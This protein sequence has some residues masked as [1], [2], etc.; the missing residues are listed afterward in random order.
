MVRNATTDSDRMKIVKSYNE[1]KDARTIAEVLGLKIGAV[2]AAIAIYKKENRDTKKRRGRPRQAALNDANKL[3]I[4]EWVD[5]DCSITL[6]RL[7]QKC[8]SELNVNASEKT[9]G[10]CLDGF[11]YTVKRV[12]I[13]PERRNTEEVRVSRAEYARRFMDVLTQTDHNLIFYLD[14]AGFS[15]SMRARRGRSAR[16]TRA[17]QV[18]AAIRTRNI[19]LMCAMSK[20]G[21]FHYSHQPRA[22]NTETFKASIDTLIINL[23]E[24]GIQNAVL[25]LDNVAFHKAQI[26]REVVER[27]GHTLMFLPPYSPFLNPIENMFSK[28]KEAVRRSRPTDEHDLIQ[29]VEAGSTLVTAEDCDGYFRHMIGFLTRCINREA[30]ID[31]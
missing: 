8:L 29:K 5:D 18:V 4:R 13:L 11:H 16:G 26:V 23:A 7:K 22:F 12:D 17:V 27:S 1:N 15:V 25:I 21:I 24:E 9:I 19:S 31:E 20:R 30:I 2:Y 6:A 14:E 28:W 10:R 3:S